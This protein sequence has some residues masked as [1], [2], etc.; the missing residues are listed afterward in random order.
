MAYAFVIPLPHINPLIH[1]SSMTSRSPSVSKQLKMAPELY[2]DELRDC[3]A[4]TL[5]VVR[6][7][8]FTHPRCSTR[9]PR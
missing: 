6:D 5:K 9:Q 2:L 3:I 4:S 7:V 8:A 1:E